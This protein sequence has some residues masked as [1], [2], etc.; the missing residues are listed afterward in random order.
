MHTLRSLWESTLAARSLH[1]SRSPGESMELMESIGV[2]KETG[3]Q[4]GHDDMSGDSK[5]VDGE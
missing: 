4:G 2:H 1:S 5:G 3:V